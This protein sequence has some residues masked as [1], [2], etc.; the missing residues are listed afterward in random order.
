MLYGFN[1]DPFPDLQKEAADFSSVD[2]SDL[3]F[4]DEYKDAISENPDVIIP[5]LP[6]A[7]KRIVED[8]VNGKV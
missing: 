3:P 1:D 4:D 5:T 7:E 8:Y 2:W 6:A